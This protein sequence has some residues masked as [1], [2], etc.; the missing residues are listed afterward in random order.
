MHF[1]QLYDKCQ[2][3]THQDGA[4]PALFQNFCVVLCIICFVSFCV[5]CVC[6]CVLYFCHRVRTQLQLNIS[7]T[8]SYHI[9]CHIIPYHIIYRI[10]SYRISYHQCF[11]GSKYAPLMQ[12]VTEIKTDSLWT[13]H[14][15]FPTLLTQ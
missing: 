4:R 12:Y 6:K 1:P 5:L 2:G 8:I 13:F 11:V 14:I 9:S 10:I 15:D 7:Y 3:I